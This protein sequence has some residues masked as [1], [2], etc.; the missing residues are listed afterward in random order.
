MSEG[1]VNVPLVVKVS[2]SATLNAA[3]DEPVPVEFVALTVELNTPAA[4]GV[5][6]ISPVDV[7]TLSPVGRPLAAKLVGLCEAAIW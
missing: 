5:P 4:V 1:T 2:V 6:E 7:F 3:E